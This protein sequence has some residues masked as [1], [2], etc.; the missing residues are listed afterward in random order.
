MAEKR[1]RPT[2]EKLFSQYANHQF[3][4]SPFGVVLVVMSLIL[5]SAL[6]DAQTLGIME[7]PYLGWSSFSQQTI[8]SDFLTQANM[9]KQSDA[10]LSSAL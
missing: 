2:K 3:P 8:A 7:K 10:L 6:G 4:G 5:G 1:C 9:S